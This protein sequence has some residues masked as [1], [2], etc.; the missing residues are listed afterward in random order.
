MRGNHITTSENTNIFSTGKS[1]SSFSAESLRCAS[2]ASFKRRDML[3][4]ATS[5]SAL[6]PP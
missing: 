6:P 1:N 4:L 5:N 3:L 2:S